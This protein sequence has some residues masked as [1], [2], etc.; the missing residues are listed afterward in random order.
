MRKATASMK[1]RVVII[2]QLKCLSSCFEVTGF[3]VGKILK[4]I[5]KYY[6]VASSEIM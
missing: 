5:L 3:L 1:Q 2:R 4:I 6:F